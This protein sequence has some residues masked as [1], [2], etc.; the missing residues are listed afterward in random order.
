[1][2]DPLHPQEKTGQPEK[3]VP[4]RQGIDPACSTEK[5]VVGRCRFATRRSLF[6]Q[7][8]VQLVLSRT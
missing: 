4:W 6:W 3:V 8:V 7:R 2:K 1:L 5:N